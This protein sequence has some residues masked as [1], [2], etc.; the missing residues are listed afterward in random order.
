MR[1][2]S[3][4]WRGIKSG[5]KFWEAGPGSVCP[6]C[7][8]NAHDCLGNCGQ[9][10]PQCSLCAGPYKLDEHRC[11]VSGC[12]TGLGKTCSHI[13]AKCANCRGNH[14]ATSV[15]CPVRHKAEREAKN[16]KDR[17]IEKLHEPLEK[18]DRKRKIG[19]RTGG[20]KSRLGHRKR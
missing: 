9:R 12:Q 10:P 15:K 6:I 3:K 17:R 7:C 20:R 2:G 13:T 8:G 19:R 5:R 18:Q 4:I 1:K 16:K 11:G 14:H